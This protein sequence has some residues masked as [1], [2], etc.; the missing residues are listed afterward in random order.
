VTADASI[1]AQL[2]RVV[3]VQAVVVTRFFLER[4]EQLM[5]LVRGANCVYEVV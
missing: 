2:E 5:T 4:E 3:G 1:L